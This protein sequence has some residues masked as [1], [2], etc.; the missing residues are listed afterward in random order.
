ME[1]GVQHMPQC[2]GTF[3][4]L[5]GFMSSPRNTRREQLETASVIQSNVAVEITDGGTSP[6]SR[7]VSFAQRVVRNAV[8][9]VAFD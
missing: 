3:T 1:T 2:G 6:R 7:I 5:T 9:R 8:S 4:S